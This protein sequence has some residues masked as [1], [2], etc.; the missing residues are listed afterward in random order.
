MGMATVIDIDFVYENIGK[1]RA[2]AK[3]FSAFMNLPD[4]ISYKYWNAKTVDLGDKV[5]KITNQQMQN[6]CAKLRDGKSEDIVDVGVSIDGAGQTRGMSAHHGFVTAISIESGQ[7]LDRHLM[8]N[9]C[10]KCDQWQEKD[11]PNNFQ[12]IH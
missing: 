7:V 11:L 3:K 10:V 2:A 12:R 5:R 1:G 8:T 6:A 4:P 9:K